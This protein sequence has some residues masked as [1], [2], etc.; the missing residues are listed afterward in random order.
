MSWGTDPGGAAADA[1][2]C[3]SHTLLRAVSSGKVTSRGRGV[4]LCHISSP[5]LKAA[6]TG[7]GILPPVSLD[8]YWFTARIPTV[9]L[10]LLVEWFSL[11][12]HFGGFQG[13]C[14]SLSKRLALQA[15]P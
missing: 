11:N 15:L 1:S 2:G 4:R 10:T 5:P 9:R 12:S 8:S 6:F 14:W 7:E 3:S 13:V